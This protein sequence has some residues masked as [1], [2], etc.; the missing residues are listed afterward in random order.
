MTK[1]KKIAILGIACLAL[2]AIGRTM[3]VKYNAY[4]ANEAGLTYDKNYPIPLNNVGID[5]LSFTAVVSSDSFLTQN[6]TDGQ[7][8][9]A[10]ITLSSQTLLNAASSYNYLYFITD[11]ATSP[12]TAASVI[13]V[14]GFPLYQGTNWFFDGTSTAATVNS[15]MAGIN[16]YVPSVVASTG[17]LSTYY[18]VYTTATNAGSAGN[19]MTLTSNIS[20]NTLL[21]S[22]SNFVGGRDNAALTINN[23]TF[24]QG[25]QWTNVYYSTSGSPNIGQGPVFN[26]TATIASLLAGINAS[27]ATT[28]V[29]VTT[30]ATQSILWASATSVGN[31]YFMSSSS[32]TQLTLAVSTLSITNGIS[33]GTMT[34]GVPASYTLQGGVYGTSVGSATAI[35]ISSHGFTDGLKVFITTTSATQTAITGLT[36][37][38]TY[39]VILNNANSISL[40]TTSA[41]A[42][43]KWPI[44]LTSSA[45]KATADTLLITPFGITGTTTLQWQVSNDG[46]YWVNYSTTDKGITVL[47]PSLTA[48]FST[49]TAT[50]WDF[51]N[52]DYAWIRLKV[53][54]PTA[55]AIGLK[56]AGNGKNSTQ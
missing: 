49:G 53:T 7:I 50:N 3:V 12:I 1:I 34:G 40:A 30:N 28:G 6:I 14:N 2:V 31:N 19:N 13:T 32:Q 42:Q 43:T 26:A 47:T 18:T 36:T 46:L 41:L 17:I 39:Y 38:G 9:T 25:T 54:A 27:S 56:V 5:Y 44:V 11:V 21:T 4:L 24:Q 45:T 8:S 22:S 37:P 33:T 29:Q 20:T 51:G 55:G 23:V 35:N 15:I 48:Y 52:V 16:K 10:T